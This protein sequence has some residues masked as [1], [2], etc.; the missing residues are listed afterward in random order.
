LGESLHQ[1]VEIVM[2]DER[3]MLITSNVMSLVRLWGVGSEGVGQVS[4]EFV[5]TR[6]AGMSHSK[7]LD[8][9]QRE[10]A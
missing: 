2:R 8:M 10:G 9:V 6:C 7:G 1:T 5:V 3:G 4:C